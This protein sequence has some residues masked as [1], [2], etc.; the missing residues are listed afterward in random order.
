L[1]DLL[2]SFSRFAEQIVNLNTKPVVSKMLQLRLSHLLKVKSATDWA[3]ENQVAD[4]VRKYKVG[5]AVKYSALLYKA[6]KKGHPGILFKDVALTLTREAGKR[7]L[8]IYLHDKIAAE[9]HWVY[10]PK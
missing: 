6:F 5:T 7:W 9:A 3:L 4:L 8:V 1:Y 10:K 2:I